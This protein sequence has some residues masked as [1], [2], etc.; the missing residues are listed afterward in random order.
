VTPAA[1]AA[2]QILQ[3]LRAGQL[4][5]VDRV[6]ERQHTHDLAERDFARVDI[7][8]TWFCFSL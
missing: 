3:D 5:I 2:R 1:A 8:P 6:V 4:D 7:L